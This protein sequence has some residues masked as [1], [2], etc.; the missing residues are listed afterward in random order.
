[1]ERPVVHVVTDVLVTFSSLV[2]QFC[3]DVSVESDRE[4]VEPQSSSFSPKKSARWIGRICRVSSKNASALQKNN[5][6]AH[7][8]A[9]F[10]FVN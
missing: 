2:T 5:D 1:M 7:A 10:A 3:Y 9:K 8:A 4:F 6:A